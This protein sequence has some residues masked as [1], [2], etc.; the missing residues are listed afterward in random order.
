MSAPRRIATDKRKNKLFKSQRWFKDS[1]DKTMGPASFPSLWT[2]RSPISLD[3]KKIWRRWWMSKTRSLNTFHR[4]PILVARCLQGRLK[5]LLRRQP[6]PTSAFTMLHHYPE[7][8][9]LW[10]RR[11]RKQAQMED[12]T[13]LSHPTILKF[14]LV[15]VESWSRS[16]KEKSQS[17]S[18]TTRID[19]RIRAKRFANFK[20]TTQNKTLKPAPSQVKIAHQFCL[21][22]DSKMTCRMFLAILRSDSIPRSVR[23]LWPTSWKV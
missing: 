20:E 17:L 7:A 21:W 6:Q 15:H 22:S 5:G 12:Q 13:Q 19:A 11:V 4:S 8:P 18:T 16:A 3:D 10:F 9:Q 2:T 1:L 14:A 23:F